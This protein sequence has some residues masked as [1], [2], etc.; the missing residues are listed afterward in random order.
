MKLASPK[1][2]R[3][4]VRKRAERLNVTDQTK[5]LLKMRLRA[6]LPI[7]LVKRFWWGN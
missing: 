5:S 1:L 6:C 2:V 3:K 7:R 4:E